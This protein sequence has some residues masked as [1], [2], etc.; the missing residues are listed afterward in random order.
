MK[1]HWALHLR[2]V[3]VTVRVFMCHPSLKKKSVRKHRGSGKPSQLA[4]CACHEANNCDGNTDSSRI[5]TWKTVL[6]C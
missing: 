6:F 1:V 2:S 5:L 3:R 4:E